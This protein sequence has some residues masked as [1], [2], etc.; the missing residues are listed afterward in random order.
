VNRKPSSA[1][2][3]KPFLRTET[4]RD[5]P[6]MLKEMELVGPFKKYVFAFLGNERKFSGSR[7]DGLIHT[8][9]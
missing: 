3:Y 7:L 9:K 5:N 8:K 2:E 1:S 6:F 4:E